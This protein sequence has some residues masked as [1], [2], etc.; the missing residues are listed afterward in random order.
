ME[1]VQSLLGDG[2]HLLLNF[3]VS[4]VNRSN[5]FEENVNR[6]YG[7]NRWKAVYE[8]EDIM[9]ACA[10]S[11]DDMDPTV[12]VNHKLQRLADD[13]CQ[14][15]REK[16]EV[17]AHPF[18]FRKGK[19][20]ADKG[21]LFYLVFATRSLYLLNQHKMGI[22]KLV[23]ERQEVVDSEHYDLGHLLV[24]FSDFFESNGQ[25][26]EL[27]RMYAEPDEAKILHARL[28]E[29]MKPPRNLG[30]WKR[31]VIEHSPFPWHART[32][33]LMVEKGSIEIYDLN[34]RKLTKLPRTC[35][36]FE[37]HDKDKGGKDK[38]L[39]NF[40]PVFFRGLTKLPSPLPREQVVDN[41]KKKR[42]NVDSDKTA[43][44]DVEGN[45]PPEST[46]VSNREIPAI[47]KAKND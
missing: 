15:M 10:I 29:T 35:D 20:R 43:E 14:A 38:E 8:D 23:Q 42:G 36:V 21:T 1:R 16:C 33:K 32:N 4:S 13:Y 9:R 41:V 22:Q 28:Y 18:A 7:D 47:K 30:E 44:K 39:T 40:F 11:Q 46:D 34:G 17:Y 3:M 19:S 26:V 12:K 2:C 31:F 25:A 45:D 27:K 37:G 6:I 5:R 24:G